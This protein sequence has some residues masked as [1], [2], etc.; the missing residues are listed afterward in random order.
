MAGFSTLNTGAGALT[1]T[2]T[3]F[4]NTQGLVSGVSNWQAALLTT[5]TG[6]SQI[7][8]HIKGTV[9][10]SIT[11]KGNDTLPVINGLQIV[12][13]VA[14]LQPDIKTEGAILEYGPLDSGTYMLLHVHGA[15]D[16]GGSMPS[17]SGGVYR[18]V[19]STNDD[20]PAIT[21]IQYP[22]ISR[23]MTGVP[24]ANAYAGYNY[25]FTH[26]GGII[27]LSLLD[28]SGH[29]TDNKS[30]VGANTSKYIISGAAYP[31][32][33]PNQP[34]APIFAL[35]DISG[36]SSLTNVTNPVIFNPTYQ[37]IPGV[38][39]KVYMYSTTPNAIIYYTYS[40]GVGT[41]EPSTPVAPV[42]LANNTAG[43]NTV[44]YNGPITISRPTK[45]K[46][47]ARSLGNTDSAMTDVYYYSPSA[48]LG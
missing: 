19:Y 48:I 21:D 39:M 24:A 4:Y 18:L 12:P 27:Q 43:T 2:S 30:A 20:P 22:E 1:L 28:I 32:D 40:I 14:F 3:P 15:I 6:D 33:P 37:A 34:L 11:G 41:G 46:A 17:F 29:Y 23:Y 38:G 16:M 31:T 45:F 10:S 9:N 7:E 35:I 25:T 13:V 36:L 44:I 8:F 42:A 47:F 5:N 26:T